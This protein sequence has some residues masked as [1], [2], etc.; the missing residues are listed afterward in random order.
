MTKEDLQAMVRP[1]SAFFG[2][3]V[4]PFINFSQ[5]SLWRFLVVPWFIYSVCEWSKWYIKQEVTK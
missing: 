4:P 1:T 5:D 2:C 3:L